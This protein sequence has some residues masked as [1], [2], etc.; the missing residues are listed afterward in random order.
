[1]HASSFMKSF[2]LLLITL[3]GFVL[4][5]SASTSASAHAINYAVIKTDFAIQ[6]N[7]ITFTTHLPMYIQS[8][9]QAQAQDFYTQYYAQQFIVKQKEFA[10]NSAI[11]NVDA[12]EQD[13]RT[14]IEGSYT[15]RDVIKSL[16]DLHITNTSFSDLFTEYDH[17]VKIKIKG[18]TKEII[19]K[20]DITTYPSSEKSQ[21][22]NSKSQ[23]NAKVQNTKTVKGLKNFDWE[24]FWIVVKQ[25]FQLGVEH[26]LTG[27]DHLLFLLS[28][29]LLL[30]SFRRIALLVTSFTIAHSITLIAAAS[31]LIFVSPKLVEPAIALSIAFMAI[32][33][34][35]ILRRKKAGSGQN[36]EIKERWLVVFGFGLI[37]GLGFAGALAER[38]IPKEHFLSALLTF[39]VGIESG[40]FMV[41]AVILPYLILLRPKKYRNKVLYGL[42]IATALIALV[43]VVQRILS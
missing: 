41:L 1:M 8:D 22:Q 31:G 29:I 34:I 9:D 21:V 14:I 11:S 10:C 23:T 28:I 5:F 40:Q 15:C 7:V 30:A 4:F 17:F 37:H 13:Q 24:N 25:F 16:T 18:S 43:W 39:N 38:G 42:S 12:S 2:R 35:W 20:K 6:D 27:Y 32:R 26:I 33:N 19:F 36:D 3:I